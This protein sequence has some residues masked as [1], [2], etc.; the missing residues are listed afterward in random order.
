MRVTLDVTRIRCGVCVRFWHRNSSIV[1]I[2]WRGRLDGLRC[3][4]PYHAERVELAAWRNACRFQRCEAGL[5]EAV[6]PRRF[7]VYELSSG[8]LCVAQKFSLA[9][10]GHM[11]LP[12]F[13]EDEPF[14]TPEFIDKGVLTDM[15]Q[16]SNRC[17]TISMAEHKQ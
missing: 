17:G 7:Q 1:Q 4:V 14:E 9:L 11:A 12:D 5:P 16:L 2:A 3:N 8:D 6:W 13:F 15:T 10:S